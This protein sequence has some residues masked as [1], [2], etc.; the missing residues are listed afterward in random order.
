[1]SRCTAGSISSSVSEACSVSRPSKG[2][3]LTAIQF[4]ND[5]G[6][7]RRWISEKLFLSDVQLD[8]LGAPQLGER[9]ARRTKGIS[10]LFASSARL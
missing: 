3:P 6:Q 9:V 10:F 4:L 2:H 7:V 8:V 5:V 1:M